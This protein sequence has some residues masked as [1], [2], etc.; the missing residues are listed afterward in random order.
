MY[1]NNNNDNSVNNDNS[2]DD[3]NNIFLFARG[4]LIRT[5]TFLPITLKS[6]LKCMKSIGQRVMNQFRKNRRVMESGLAIS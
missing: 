6:N 1:Y 3:N 4:S 5:K 2:N